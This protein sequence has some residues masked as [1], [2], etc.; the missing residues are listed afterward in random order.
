MCWME[1]VC[2]FVWFWFEFARNSCECEGV[3]MET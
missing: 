3:G 2:A 1:M